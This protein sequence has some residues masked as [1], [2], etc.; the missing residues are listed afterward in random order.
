MFV[1]HNSLSRTKRVIHF[2]YL[3]CDDARTVALEPT[4]EGRVTDAKYL[5]A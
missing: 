2:W 5:G 1:F 4:L 3:V